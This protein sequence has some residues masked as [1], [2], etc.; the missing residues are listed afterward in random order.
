[1]C[2]IWAY[3]KHPGARFDADEYQRVLPFADRVRP[4][5]P[6]K[7]TVVKMDRFM[8]TFHRLAI[9]DLSPLGD[10]PFVFR[11]GHVI[12]Y[13]I[14]NGEI[15]NHKE[16]IAKYGFRTTSGS[17]CEVI[18]PLL[19]E[20]GFDVGSAL[21]ELEGEFAFVVVAHDT[22]HNKVKVYAA[23]DR[24]GVRPLFW[25]ETRDGLVFSSVLAGLAGLTDNA[26]VFTP[27]TFVVTDELGCSTP[28]NPKKRKVTPCTEVSHVHSKLWSF[29][30]TY[31]GFGYPAN[32]HLNKASLY[33][34]V[35]SR[36][37]QA[38]RVRLEAD[39]PVGCLLSGGLDSSLVAAIMVK[40][41]GVKDLRTFTIGMEDGTD[42]AYARRVADH[43]GTRHT[44]VRF[45]PQEA[46]ATIPE[47]VRATETWDIT[48]NRASVCQY[49]LA[50]HIRE[51]TDIRVILNGDGADEVQSGYLYNYYC[52]SEAEGHRDAVRLVKE[53]HLFDGLRVDRC[54]SCHGLEAR[55]PFLDPHFVDYFLSLP[56]AL[57]LPSKSG[58]AE[59][60]LIRDAFAALYPDLLPRE[61]LYRKKDAFSD[62]V[63]AKTKSWYQIIQEHVDGIVSDAEYHEGRHRFSHHP[64]VSKES[65]YYR[66]LFHEAF[67][68]RYATVIPHYWLPR[69]SGNTTEPS[70]RT[71]SVYD[72]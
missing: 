58:R 67:G 66:K 36:L 21:Q 3:V 40:I 65:Y 48:T 43:L 35:T 55:V 23:R 42:V 1:M 59:K 50:K 64:P 2:G 51:N 56:P 14:C 4:R 31:Y 24:I 33:W 18:Y 39:V 57:R 68:D 46:L 72:A 22:A 7:T 26:R 15:Y 38:V 32:T 12:S 19:K 63:S 16:I 20:H 11:E 34:D 8:L 44:Q 9:N 49:L 52:P 17:D 29:Q 71:L 37:I 30:H 10:Q 5:G 60:Q 61:V 41:L 47:V 13:V 45:T 70:A 25:G 54:I 69:W 6:D 27:G 62:G 53:I 28:S